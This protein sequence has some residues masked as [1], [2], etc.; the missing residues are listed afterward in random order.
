MELLASKKYCILSKQLES[1]KY[2][3]NTSCPLLIYFDFLVSKRQQIQFIT[4][5]E[6]MIVPNE[7]FPK[8]KLGFNKHDKQSSQILIT[9]KKQLLVS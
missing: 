9:F 1:N 3:M 8:F 5:H 4:S 6:V 7:K 2:C